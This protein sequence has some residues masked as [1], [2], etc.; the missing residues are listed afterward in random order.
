MHVGVCLSTSQK[1]FFL[2]AYIFWYFKMQYPFVQ[3]IILNVLILAKKNYQFCALTV[4]DLFKKKKEPLCYSNR[5]PCALSMIFQHGGT[6]NS[7]ILFFGYAWWEFNS[8]KV[9]AC[10]N[11][12]K[13]TMDTYNYLC[14]TENLF[15][16]KTQWNRNLEPKRWSILFLTH[17]DVL[18]CCPNICINLN[19]F[20]IIRMFIDLVHYIYWYFDEIMNKI[21]FFKL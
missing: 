3:D 16:E 5:F 13:K 9:C 18:F 2:K 19:I 21:Q 1:A 6:I 7:I 20:S 14:L 4:S 11:T 15:T 12:H 8:V 17:N 10:T